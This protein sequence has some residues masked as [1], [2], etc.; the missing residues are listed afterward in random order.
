MASAWY[1]YELRITYYDGTGK[2]KDPR[3]PVTQ[4]NSLAPNAT[5]T[6]AM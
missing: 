2:I 5:G 6:D 1:A 3:D 4:S